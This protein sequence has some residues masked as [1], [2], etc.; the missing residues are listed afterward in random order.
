MKMEE[1]FPREFEFAARFAADKGRMRFTRFLDP[2]QV[3]CAGQAAREQGVAFSCWGGYE[4]AERVMGCFIPGTGTWS[5][6]IS[7]LSACA[8]R[9]LRN[10]VPFR[11]GIFSALLWLWA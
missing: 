1:E 2:A 8:R 9:F 6:R 7:R 3:L 10:S 5:R 4:Q 11:T